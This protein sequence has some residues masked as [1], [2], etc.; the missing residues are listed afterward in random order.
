MDE[1]DDGDSSDAVSKDKQL[2]SRLLL[3]KLLESYCKIRLLPI[4]LVD[5]ES[6]MANNMD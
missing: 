4:R 2:L 3:L 5:L 1:C 6:V